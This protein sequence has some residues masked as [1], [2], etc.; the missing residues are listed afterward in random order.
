MR[1]TFVIPYFYPA[2]QYGG[3]PRVAFEMARSM[4]KRGHQ[5]NVLTTDSGGDGRIPQSAID[6]IH[7]NGVDGIQA[8]YYR[9]VSDYLAYKQRLF[10]PLGFLLHVKERLRDSEIVHIHDLRS[11]L[12]VAAHSALRSLHKPYVL[13]PHGGLKHLGKRPAKALFD[14]L[15][16]KRILHD[17]A[18]LCAI[19]PVEEKDAIDFG[20]EP[21]RIYRFPSAINTAAYQ[22]L[23]PRGEF[24]SRWGLNGRQI[25]LFLGRLHWVK[26]VDILIESIALLK[27]LP[28]VHLVIAGP[29]DGAESKL[30]SLA[31]K[32]GL[33]GRVTFTGFLDHPEK[34][35]A[36]VDSDL[37]VVSSRSEAFALALLEG[38]ACGTPVILSSACELEDWMPKNSAWSTFRKEDPVDLANQL[39]TA[40]TGTRDEKGLAAVRKLVMTEFSSEALTTRAER[41]YQSLLLTPSSVEKRSNPLEHRNQA[42]G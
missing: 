23:P 34:A 14:F 24:A 9:N 40:L 16:G 33:E 1:I 30:R 4:V 27:D 32:R 2:M 42:R 10:L 5:V 21:R 35:Q 17:A 39:R 26:G 22:E 37:V 18:G 36:L 28:N 11:F 38:L 7:E 41:L 13:S 20:I 8:Y 25:V 15:W 6:D 29:D 19:S 3:T 31:R 12:S